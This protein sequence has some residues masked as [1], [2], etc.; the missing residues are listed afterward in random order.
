MFKLGKVCCVGALSGLAWLASIDQ[1]L[2][3]EPGNFGN[4][5][6]GTSM[7]AILGAAPPPGLYFNNTMFYL[8]MG[9]GNGNTTCGPGCKTRFNGVGDSVT[10]TWGSGLKFLGGTYYPVANIV[11]YQ[12]SA[13]TVPYPPGGGPLQSPIYGNTMNIMISNLTLTPLNFSWDLGSAWFVSAGLG[14][15]AP[16]GTNY[17]G[18]TLPDYWAVVPRAAISYLGNGWNFT[19]GARYD[20][21]MSSEGRTG[22][23]QAI[24]RNPA[25]PL[26][27]ASFLTGTANPGDGYTSGNTLY[28]DWTATKKFDK[29]EIGPVGAFRWQTNYDTPGGTNP[30]TGAAWTCTQLTARGLPSCGKD[31]DV[32]VGLLI[33]YNFGPVDMKFIYSNVVY[34]K[35]SPGANTG[36]EFFLKTSF[37]LWAPDEPVK[38]PLITK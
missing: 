14:F 18:A 10:F 2:A 16:I 4:Y 19:V 22:A 33:G 30:A 17:A 1:S 21:N 34:S 24:A 13:T 3:T 28:V 37:R 12:A 31:I 29:W 5:L 7:G 15:V 36:S 9:S 11:G 32:T 20:I 25:T 6:S 35:D 26:A 27:L 8:P 23:Y 38:K